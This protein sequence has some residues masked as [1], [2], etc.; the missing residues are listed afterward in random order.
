MS[1]SVSE[2]VVSTCIPPQGLN[3]ANMSHTHTGLDTDVQR[4]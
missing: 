4:H 2:G 1:E 3:Y